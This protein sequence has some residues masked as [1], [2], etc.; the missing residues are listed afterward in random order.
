MRIIEL[1]YTT[2]NIT[3]NLDSEPYN[4]VPFLQQQHNTLRARHFDATHSW[5]ER[6]I[7]KRTTPYEASHPP[8][9]TDR[10]SVKSRIIQTIYKLSKSSH[11]QTFSFR[12]HGRTQ[13]RQPALAYPIRA[14]TGIK[15][16]SGTLSCNKRLIPFP[17]SES[18]KERKQGS[19]KLLAST[20]MKSCKPLKAGGWDKKLISYC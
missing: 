9:A 4:I 5:P 17:R 14:K 6:H 13:S 12:K 11:N 7:S 3:Q 20:P 16:T 8:E 19:C 2:N 18:C 15:G 10:V 1:H